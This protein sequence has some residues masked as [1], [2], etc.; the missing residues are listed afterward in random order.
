M[1]MKLTKQILSIPPYISTTWGHVTSLFLKEEKGILRLVVVLK[2]GAQ[3]EIPNLPKAVIDRVFDI[4]ANLS[5]NHSKED[6]STPVRLTLP[7]SNKEDGDT[8]EAFG[9]STQ[10]NPAQSELPPLPPKV[11]KKIS[12]LAHAFGMETITNLPQ[13]EPGC[14]C[15][16]CQVMNAVRGEI[17]SGEEL[18]TEEDLKFKNWDVKQTAEKLYKVTNPIDD[19]E[20]YSVFLGE[21][22]GCTCGHKNCEHIRAVLT[23]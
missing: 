13:S 20:N 5:E 23:T 2:D 19:N 7:F 16:Y 6:E 15:I 22:I 18:I 9:A 8:I 12:A 3:V 14:N 1:P 21:P 17:D 11:L 10:H 4:H